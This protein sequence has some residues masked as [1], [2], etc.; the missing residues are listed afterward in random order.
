MIKNVHIVTG[1]PVEPS[2]VPEDYVEAFGVLS[3]C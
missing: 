2:H 1:P 3:R